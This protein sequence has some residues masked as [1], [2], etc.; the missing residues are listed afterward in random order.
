MFIDNLNWGRCFGLYVYQLCGTIK[1]FPLLAVCIGLCGTMKLNH[2][3]KP[4]SLDPWLMRILCPEC[5]LPSTSEK[6]PKAK[7][8]DYIAWRVSS[9]TLTNHLKGN[10]P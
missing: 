8:I 1:F 10:F 3:K 5:T 9:T 7:A 2:K 4:F 6:K